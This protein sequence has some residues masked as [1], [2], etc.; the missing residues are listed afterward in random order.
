[1]TGQ[2]F[3]YFIHPPSL[4]GRPSIFGDPGPC[5][6]P[7]PVPVISLVLPSLMDLG[8]ENKLLTL[9]PSFCLLC[10]L[11]HMCKAGNT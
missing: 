1:M 2:T 5:V 9:C 10:P 3:K 4:G 8:L 11:S 6:E 7:T